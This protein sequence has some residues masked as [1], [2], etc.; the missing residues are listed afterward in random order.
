LSATREIPIFPL[1]TVLFPGGM[2]PLRIFEQRY[3]EMTK[4]CIRDNAPFGVCLIRE[5][6]EVGAPAV[7]HSVGCTARILRWDMP[8]L[9]LFQLVTEGDSVFRILEQ[10]SS[11]TGLLYA[12][13][14]LDDPAPPLPLPEAFESL[15]QLLE[16][17]ISKVGAER[18]PAPARLDEAAWVA[19]RLAES[20]P[21]EASLRQQLLEVR[22]PLAALNE[23]K[24]FL[25]SK[26]VT[27]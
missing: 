1:G 24:T 4:L 25:Q 14:E 9:G 12:Q 19:Y 23:V 6:Q 26:S 21:M 20:L 16:T 7:P 18:F 2:L 8:H 13:V 11:R 10:W 15:A 27:V 22:D 5:G 3:L 17:I